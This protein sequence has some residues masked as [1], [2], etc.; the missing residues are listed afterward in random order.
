VGA[1]ISRPDRSVAF[2]SELLS[3]PDPEKSRRAMKAMLQMK[4]IDI[5]TLK[6]ASDRLGPA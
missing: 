3:D 5:E 6:Q 1:S 2:L 4:K